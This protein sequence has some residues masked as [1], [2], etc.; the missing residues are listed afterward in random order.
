VRAAG[1]REAEAEALND[2][3][4]VHTAERRH[5]EAI[6]CHRQSLA[7]CRELGDHFQEARAHWGLGAAA[8]AADG[9]PAAWPHWAVALAIFERLDV[10]E[11]DDLR[12]LL[13]TV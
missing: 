5:Q 6:A 13:G 12:R 7:I 1:D 2:L 9:P 8:A 3:G 11:A 10:P 4:Q